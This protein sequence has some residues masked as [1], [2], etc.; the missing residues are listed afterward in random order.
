MNCKLVCL[1]LFCFLHFVACSDQSAGTPKISAVTPSVVTSLSRTTLTIEGQDLFGY[2][3]VELASQS[4]PTVDETWF[5]Q[6]GAFERISATLVDSQT[7]TFSFPAGAPPGTYDVV[8]Q[9]PDGR[10]ARLADSLT[11]VSDPVGLAISVETAAGGLG[12]PL[13]PRGIEAGT[14]VEAFAVLREPSGDFVQDIEVAWSLEQPIGAIAAGPS[15]STTLEAQFVGS[16]VIVATHATAEQGKSGIIEVL[17]GLATRVAIED[18][19]GGLGAEVLELANL[20]TDDDLT[21]YAI[22]RDSFGNFVNSDD[23]IWSSTGTLQKIDSTPA[24]NLTISLATPGVG[25]VLISDA[26]L[27]A[28]ETGTLTV[29][30]GQANALTVAP[31]TL[32]ISADDPASLFSVTGVDADG[33]ATS[34]LGTI[35][36]SIATGPITSIDSAAGLF[37]PIAAGTGSVR[38]TSSYGATAD[39][40]VITVLPGLVA[41]LAISP[42]T[43]SV[44]ADAAA[45]AFSAFATDAD[46]NPTSDVGVLTWSV[47]SGT[48]SSIDS[49]SGSFTPTN[50]GNGS[51]MV[52]SSL[53]PSATSGAVSVAPGQ[54]TSL[55]VAPDSLTS[56]VGDAPTV[57]AVSAM[58]A[59]GNDTGDTGII[60][61]SVS[62][63]TSMNSASGVF[64]PTTFGVGVVT[65]TSSLGISDDTGA[66]EVHAA[67]EIVDLVHPGTA[68]QSTKGVPLEIQVLNRSAQTV[69]LTGVSISFE[70]SSVDVTDEFVAVAV[71]GMAQQIGPG[72]TVGLMY[73]VGILPTATEGTIGI[74]V[75]V[76]AFVPLLGAVERARDSSSWSVASAAPIV[77]AITAPVE[78]DNQICVGESV[79]FDGSSST[80]PVLLGYRWDF[81]GGAP[82][83]STSSAP[84]GI[85]YSAVGSFLYSLT[86]SSLTSEALRYGNSPIFVGVLEST[87]A[88]QYPTGP[89]SF[90]KPTENEAIDMDVLPKDNLVDQN[91]SEAIT[92]CDGSEID[93]TGHCYVTLFSDR[94]VLDLARD[95][96]PIQPGI[97]V[98][99]HACTHFDD[100]EFDNDSA[101]LEGTGMLYAEFHNEALDAVTASGFVGFRMTNDRVAPTVV[102]TSP[103]AACSTACYGKGNPLLFA[104]SEP[105]DASSIVGGTRVETSS[106]SDCTG[107]FTEIT[108]ASAIVYDA[109]SRT[110]RVEPAL[111]A[112]STYSVRVTLQTSVTDSASNANPI[113]APFSFCVVATD[114]PAAS[115]PLPPTAVVLSSSEFSPDG[116]GLDDIVSVSLDVGAST[117]AIVLALRRGDVVVREILD[118][119]D[120]AGSY[121]IAWDGRDNDGRVVPNGYYA[122]YLTTEST[123]GIVSSPVISVVGVESAVSFVGVTPRF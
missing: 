64:T 123:A 112:A 49:T 34:D 117:A 21:L 96:D 70:S 92:Q 113:A 60:T 108:G 97:Q 28:D 119:V 39:S 63:V 65:A 83:A 11:V 46:N 78:P 4:A 106:T 26:T 2:A 7:L 5:V 115:P 88:D 30:A 35:S 10:S 8:A 42:N 59:D 14:S 118:T 61:W 122:L 74:D 55:I 84:L 15:T 86:I 22:R 62:N 58:D 107:S 3:S 99:L 121:N 89:L 77:V 82:I 31:D 90:Q 38:A 105:M 45:F 68:L 44:T 53:G 102:A 12:A 57:F 6:I 76:E 69:A 109:N 71:P 103:T 17:P 104:F 79:D 50:A 16:A 56:F 52:E 36:W 25:T 43:A 9:G 80:A 48:I 98:D 110:A 1:V 100:V 13:G 116:D 33:N 54:A 87:P 81:S 114:L 23:V 111:Q 20:S 32:T 29:V 73:Q 19:A 18:A 93:Q 120:G 41:A 91:T 66:V 101:H 72:E 47:A 27:G 94:G 37:D 51:V 95:I 75:E 24:A 85:S 40:S 67:L